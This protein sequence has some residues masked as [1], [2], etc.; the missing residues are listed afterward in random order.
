MRGYAAPLLALAVLSGCSKPAADEG[1]SNEVENPASTESVP[2]VPAPE[3]PLPAIA[4]PEPVRGEWGINAADCDVSTG[5]AKGNLQIGADS[6]KFYESVAKL[7]R[8]N[9]LSKMGIGAE[10]KFS[11]EGQEWT[12]T[13]E[14]SV[15]PDSKTLTRREFGPDAMEEP[16]TYQRCPE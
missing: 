11:G 14:L 15:S 6:L 10:F 9:S 2:S 12:R 5:A 4:I 3:T 16:L 13:M 7:D 8:V 1:T